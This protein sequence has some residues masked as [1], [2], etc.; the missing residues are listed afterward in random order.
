MYVYVWARVSAI[1][2]D[3]GWCLHPHP[4][5]CSLFR[6]PAMPSPLLIRYWWVAP[7][8]L[9]GTRHY[10]A[11]RMATAS[12]R[13]NTKSNCLPTSRRS[14][15]LCHIPCGIWYRL[16]LWFL[17]FHMGGEETPRT[18]QVASN[19]YPSRERSVW[20]VPWLDMVSWHIPTPP[21]RSH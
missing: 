12:H 11:H 10:L 4:N 9:G 17:S 18:N 15:M 7:V 19:G 21:C 6:F 14:N 8:C 5:R 16:P 2:V 13:T 1:G 3:A 20:S